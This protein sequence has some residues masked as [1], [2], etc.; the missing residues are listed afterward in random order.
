MKGYQMLLSELIQKTNV[1]KCNTDLNTEIAG[2]SEKSAQCREG[3]AFVCLKGIHSD[4]NEYIAEA[5][6]N[7]AKVI[8][9][10]SEP[11]ASVPYVKVENARKALAR[12]WAAWYGYPSKS[13]KLIGITGTNGKTSTAYMLKSILD[14]AGKRAGLIGTVRYITGEN[15][16]DSEM[17]T[18]DPEVMQKL[19]YE[20][21]QSGHE[22]VVCEVSSHALAL[23]KLDGMEFEMGIFTNLSQ[24]HLDFHGTLEEY[25]K[26]K[27]KLF[28]MCKHGVVNIDNIYGKR[29]VDECNMDFTTCS[30]SSNEADICAKNIRTK[31]N[32]VEYEFLAALN[33]YRICCPVPGMFSVYNSLLAAAAADKMGISPE[34]ITGGIKNMGMVLGRME[35]VETGRDFSIIIDF[36][37]TPNALQNVLTSIRQYAT[38]RVVCLF[39][40]GGDRDKSK[41]EVMGKIAAENSDYV[42]ITSDNPRNEDPLA[43]IEDILKGVRTVDE[44]KNNYT[45]IESREEAIRYAIK[46]AKTDDTILLAGK[47]H[48]NYLVDA[49]GKHPFDERAIV[50]D[51]LSKGK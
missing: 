40:C 37:H 20:M 32:S 15:E 22:Y 49:S 9:T 8:I 34:Y 38:G 41:R 44:I 43:I 47:G 23:D 13:L 17:T 42:I 1:L 26:A 31:E 7:G 2:I 46:N 39:G 12:M 6:A 19:L 16:S 21:K 51:E 24:D 4:G 30:V 45:V 10:E 28:S 11:D 25:Y 48:E 36:A 27:K 14:H 3:Y 29:L 50:K 5:L 35:R 33:I 18:P